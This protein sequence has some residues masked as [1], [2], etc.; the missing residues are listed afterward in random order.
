MRKILVILS[1]VLLSSHQVVAKKPPNENLYND[2]LLTIFSGKLYPQSEQPDYKLIYDTLITTLFPSIDKEIINYYGYPKQFES[3]KILGI[4]REHEGSFDFNAEVQ[5]TTFEHAHDPPYG[6]ETMTFNISPFGVKTTSFQHEGDKLEQDINEF[7]KATL[8]D[9]KQSFN[10]NLESYPSYTYNQLQY[11]AEI[12]NEFKSLFNIA[13][14]IV[15]SILLPE[16]KIPNKNVIDPVTFIK[17][18]T[19]Y[20]LFKK[21][22]GTN[23]NYKVQKKDGNWIVTEKNSKQGKKMD[24]KIPWYVWKKIKPTD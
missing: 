12:N 22:D 18:N 5:V 21:S 2:A 1:F 16:R 10:L 9:I 19:G 23:V 20:I 15:S 3:A 24:Y 14:E 8:S 7:Y 11:Q 4:T 17:D 6:K 13:E